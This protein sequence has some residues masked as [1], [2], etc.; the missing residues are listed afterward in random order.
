MKTYLIPILA[1]GLL[2]SC[3][4]DNN[5]PEDSTEAAHDANDVKFDKDSH[6]KDAEFAV[7][8]ADGG[9]FEV[10]AADLA[11]SKTT[12]AD[13]KAL[14]EMMKKDHSTANT[15]LKALAA[16][17]KITL[18]DSL[19]EDKMDKIEK[20]REKSGADFDKAYV[21]MMVDDHDKDIQ[22]FNKE[23]M[24]GTE[25]DIRNWAAQKL[26]TLRHH[27]DMAKETKDKLK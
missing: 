3:D 12:N 23:S 16:T 19:S 20:L 7:K 5:K 25:Q 4:N 26:P 8:A 24:D 2:C 14:A 1:L 18:P 27:Y 22:L 13:V 6:E 15:E 21:D 11:L 9:M 17:K 10:E